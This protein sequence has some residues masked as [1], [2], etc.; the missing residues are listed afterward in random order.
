MMERIVIS[1]KLGSQFDQVRGTSPLSFSR[2][3]VQFTKAK[4][5]A[6]KIIFFI[7]L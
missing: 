7:F 2:N 6:K 3:V 5:K 1:F 4:I